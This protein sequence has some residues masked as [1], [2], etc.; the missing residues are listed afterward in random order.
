MAA[1]GAA[2]PPAGTKVTSNAHATSR[3][4]GMAAKR[5]EKSRKLRAASRRLSD[6][7][8]VPSCAFLWRLNCCFLV[9][10]VL[11]Y[12]T[13]C[14]KSSPLALILTVSNADGHGWGISIRLSSAEI[15]DVCGRRLMARTV[16][17]T[18]TEF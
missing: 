6:L 1:M 18:D 16:W 3:R 15:C 10:G 5:H 9:V 2:R 13:N 14:T 12:A 17:L 7:F 11:Q 4:T 8:F